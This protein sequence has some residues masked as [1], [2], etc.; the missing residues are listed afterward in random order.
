[1]TFFISY[2][3]IDR[4]VNYMKGFTTWATLSSRGRVSNVDNIGKRSG[5]QRTYAAGRGCRYIATR[6]AAG[7]APRGPDPRRI[8]HKTLPSG[9]D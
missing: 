3:R 1:M 5:N 6:P 4:Y 9:F 2:N 7:Y 8:P